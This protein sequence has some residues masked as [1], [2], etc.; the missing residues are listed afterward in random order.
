MLADGGRSVVTDIAYRDPLASRCGE[1]NIVGSGGG[2]HDQLQCGGRHC[3][4]ID[5]HF[6]G[7]HHLTSVY[8][9]EHLTRPGRAVAD[10][11]VQRGV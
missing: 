9:L 7:A 5:D 4:G 1:V 3:R 8:P 10:P 6:V 11:V 2:D